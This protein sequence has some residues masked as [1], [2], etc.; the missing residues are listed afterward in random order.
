MV[1]SRLHLSPNA[2]DSMMT[3]MM[4]FGLLL[5]MRHAL[6]ADHVAAVATLVSRSRGAGD[7]L[8]HGAAWGLGHTITLLVFGSVVLWADGVVPVELARWLELLVGVML[9]GLGLD[10]LWRLWR[11]RIHFHAHEHSSDSRHF[12]AHSHAGEP[13]RGHDP[14]RHSHSHAVPAAGNRLAGL[15]LRALF[16]GLMHGMAGSAVLILL[17]LETID[18]PWTGMAY[19]ALF[20]LG[21]MVGMA[22]LSVVIALPLRRSANGLT[23]FHNG[24][25]AVIGGGTVV[26]GVGVVAAMPPL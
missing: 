11:D 3:A 26:L 19:M 12:H 23:W 14:V 22:L 16:I 15:P 24:L 6:E 21:S 20:G 1:L 18:S 10:V 4:L 5:G 8:R 13:R 17:T 2:P 25:Q 9:I 7:A